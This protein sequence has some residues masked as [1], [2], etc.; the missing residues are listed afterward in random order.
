VAR[1]CSLT[2]GSFGSRLCRE[3]VFRILSFQLSSS[4]SRF[5]N[6]RLYYY[7]ILA[8]SGS[9]F[10]FIIL[11]AHLFLLPQFGFCNQPLSN[12]I[13]KKVGNPLD[14]KICHILR[15]LWDPTPSCTGLANTCSAV[16]TLKD[17]TFCKC[18]VI[19]YI[20][21]FAFPPVLD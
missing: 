8:S 14:R 9:L 13:D 20:I 7:L 21:Y 17:K 19:E 1:P 12:P 5:S 6:N 11:P 15:L 16:Q 3:G 18:F 10:L 4:S 2:R